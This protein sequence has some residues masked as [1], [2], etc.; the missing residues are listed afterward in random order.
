MLLADTQIVSLVP[1]A[2][3]GRV[4]VASPV[5]V[6]AATCK[7]LRLLLV[8]F[9]KLMTPAFV[10]L[11]S[12]TCPPSTAN[13]DAIVVAPFNET[14]PVPVLKVPAPVWP[15]LPVILIPLLNEA[16]PETF[17]VPPIDVAPPTVKVP[18]PVTEVLPF[19]EIAP[20]PVPNEPLPDCAKLPLVCVYPVTPLT[21][22]ADVT[23]RP[24]EAKLKLAPVLPI[25][26]ELVPLVLIAVVP[27]T[28]SPLLS[29]V[30]PETPSVPPSVV[31]PLPTVKV[32]LP[33]TAVL[34]FS[35]IAP[36]P[37]VN[38][39]VPLWLKLPLVWL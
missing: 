6:G 1:P 13:V 5:P 17:K 35:E 34:P 39:P 20:V 32:L 24:V 29:V 2:M 23:F 27:K 10:A 14:A 21:M 19:S 11:P 9:V 26:V 31:A 25:V 8:V 36:V 18:D 37:V 28:F 4:K 3:L 30:R 38:V 7:I 12:V 16:A 15:K 22:P 33:E